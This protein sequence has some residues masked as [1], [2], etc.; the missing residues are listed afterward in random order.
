MWLEA[1]RLDS[2]HTQSPR[3]SPARLCHLLPAVVTP[4]LSHLSLAF[5]PW[6]LPLCFL[7]ASH[8]Y[9]L[10]ELWSLKYISQILWE[11]PNF[12]IICTQ[13]LLVPLSLAASVS[14]L[15]PW[16]S[17]CT[18]VSMGASSMYSRGINTRLWWAKTSLK[19][20]LIFSKATFWNSACNYRGNTKEMISFIP[21]DSCFIITEIHRNQIIYALG[22][23]L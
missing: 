5:L 4:S 13:P 16:G 14:N 2:A 10:H 22:L 8:D 23:L 20:L 19:C 15:A 12:R 6:C 21:S 3:G 1:A 17:E 11:D 18:R 9:L 7:C